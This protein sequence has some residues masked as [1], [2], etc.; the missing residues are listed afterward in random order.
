VEDGHRPAAVLWSQGDGEGGPETPWW[1]RT[2][3]RRRVGEEAG[4]EEVRPAT[5]V[6]HG[7]S[8]ATDC[9]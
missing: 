8:R 4:A 7:W 3:Q 9:R 5:L 2:G 1:R 6:T